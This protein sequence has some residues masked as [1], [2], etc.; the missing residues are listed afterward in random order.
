MNRLEL[1]TGTALIGAGVFTIHGIYTQHAGPLADVRN[2]SPST[3]AAA[4][5]LRDADM[6]AGGMTLL[7]GGALSIATGRWYPLGLAVLAFVIVASYYHATL[8]GPSAEPIQGGDTEDG[9]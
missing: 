5:R 7:A 6:L 4:Q 2:D 1:S 9:Y 8:R 3:V